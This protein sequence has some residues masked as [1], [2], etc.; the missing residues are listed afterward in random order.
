VQ[1]AAGLDGAV[2][3]TVKFLDG[4]FAVVECTEDKP[5]AVGAEVAGEI[6][7]GHRENPCAV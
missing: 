6:M 4:D 3:K 2:R 7:C 1:S 5:T